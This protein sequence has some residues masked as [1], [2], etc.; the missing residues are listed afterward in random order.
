M[1]RLSAILAFLRSRDPEPA[2]LTPEERADIERG[3]ADLAAGRVVPHDEVRRWLE[4]W[5]KPDELST[6]RC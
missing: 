6:P 3:E 5:G 2:P 4:S 1:G